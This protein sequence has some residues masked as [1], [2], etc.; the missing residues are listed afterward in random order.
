METNLENGEG[1][2]RCAHTDKG[3]LRRACALSVAPSLGCPGV[4]R[5]GQAQSWA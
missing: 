2:Q 1:G 5:P 4:V 3:P